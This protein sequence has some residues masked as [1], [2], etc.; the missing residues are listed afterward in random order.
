MQHLDPADWDALRSV[1]QQILKV[2]K[3]HPNAMVP[4]YGG[5]D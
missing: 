3:L 5:T 4:T 1:P 2:K